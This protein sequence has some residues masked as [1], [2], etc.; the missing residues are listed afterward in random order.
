MITYFKSKTSGEKALLIII[1][2]LVVYALVIN[3]QKGVYKLRY[4]KEV[5]QKYTSAQ[6]SISVLNLKL[7]QLV[8][9]N[10]AQTITDRRKS[11]SIDD[12]L[13]SDEK[14]IDNS[15]VTDDELDEFLARYNQD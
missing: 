15:T 13:K 7:D 14:T 12:K 2:V 1:A 11:K 10:K 6:D 8:A 4:Y 5:E 3:I 9:S